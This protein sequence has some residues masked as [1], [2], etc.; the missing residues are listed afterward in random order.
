M[1]PDLKEILILIIE[2]LRSLERRQD[3]D[4]RLLLQ[5]DSALQGSPL[6]AAVAQYRDA[7]AQRVSIRHDPAQDQRIDDII[8]RLKES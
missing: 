2:R 6:A 7:S 8:Q 4:A 5:I 3:S 1:E